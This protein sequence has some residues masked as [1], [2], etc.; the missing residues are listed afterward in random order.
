MDFEGPLPPG[1]HI[2][3][4]GAKVYTKNPYVQTGFIMEERLMVRP[5]PVVQMP[6]V[7]KLRS[8]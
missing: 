5:L 1:L 4:G 8:L 7:N 3:L 6:R 2:G